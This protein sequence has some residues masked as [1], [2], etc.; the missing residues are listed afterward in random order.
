MNDK[1]LGVAASP[2]GLR[3]FGAEPAAQSQA[4]PLVPNAGP[5]IKP[6][7]EAAAAYV[8]RSGAVGRPRQFPSLKSAPLG[9]RTTPELREALEIAAANNRRTLT[10]EVEHRLLRSFSDTGLSL[11]DAAAAA[12]RRT[13]EE[14]LASAMSGSAQDAQRLDPEGAP[15]RSREAGDATPSTG[16]FS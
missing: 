14:A 7:H 9:I 15:A 16:Q 11:A 10:Q 1:S 2:P 13:V 5:A 6:L 12:I 8:K 4:E 3:P